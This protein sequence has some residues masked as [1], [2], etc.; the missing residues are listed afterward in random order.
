MKKIFTL[1]AVAAMAMGAQAQDQTWNFSTWEKGS[2]TADTEKDGLTVYAGENYTDE[3][4]EEVKQNVD[5]DSNSKTAYGVKYTQRLKTGGSITPRG[6]RCMSINV[7]GNTT[8]TFIATSSNSSD[9]RKLWIGTSLA[10]TPKEENALAV[11]DINPGD[12]VGYQYKYTGGAATLYFGSISGGMNFYAVM[13]GEN[14]IPQETEVM[15]EANKITF[16]TDG[17]LVDLATKYNGNGFILKRIDSG[18]KHAI[19][20]NNAWFGDATAQVKHTSQLKVGGKSSSSNALTLT[21]PTAGYLNICVRTGS[22]GATDRNLVLTQNGTELYNKV[23]QEADKATVEI[24]SNKSEENPT[25]ATSVYPIITVPVVAG[26]VQI[27]YPVGAL[28][29][30]CFEL[31]NSAGV[32]AVK[33]TATT[34]GAMYNLAGQK[35]ADDFK[36]LVI[37]NGKKMIKK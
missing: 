34:N 16:G 31:S 37:M 8:L 35:V 29:F 11:L 1:I 15:T 23:V 17:N 25:G 6:K 26:T 3:K 32:E 24:E 30:Y 13:T 14:A 33:A 27:G 12:P 36:G 20:A 28:N 10:E 22:S 18:G 7:T 4:N 9:V 21:I 2:L 5:I 19:A